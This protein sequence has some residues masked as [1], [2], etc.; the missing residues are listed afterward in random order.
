MIH[1]KILKCYL[2]VLLSINC[3]YVHILTKKINDNLA[4]LLDINYVLKYLMHVWM[5]YFGGFLIIY[6]KPFKTIL[7][8]HFL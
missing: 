2:L 3:S 1:D 7:I 4:I 8:I 5:F 6:L